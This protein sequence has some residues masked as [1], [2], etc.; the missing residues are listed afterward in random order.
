MTQTHDGPARHDVPPGPLGALAGAAWQALLVAGLVSVVL[1]I[2]VL[3]WPDASLRV[4]GVLFGLYLL[5]SGVMQLVAAFGTHATT[6]LRVMAFISGALSILLGLFCF[7]GA[8]QSTLLL[9]LWIGIGWL[10]RG[11]TQT[12]AAASDPAMPARGWQI[13]LGVV[14]AVAGV[15][16]I[17]SPLESARVLAVLAGVWLI[18]VGL[19]ELVTAFVIRSRA[20]DLP[21]GA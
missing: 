11:I 4:A 10:F 15:V 1:G 9:A 17:V 16:L 7:R 20:K 21:Q 18:V 12:V 19:V 2:L 13:F 8:M 5:F 3:V 14:S 6:A